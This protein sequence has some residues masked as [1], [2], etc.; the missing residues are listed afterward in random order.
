[1]IF[2]YTNSIQAGT[3]AYK[4]VELDDYLEGKC[5]QHREIQGNE[6]KNFIHLFDKLTILE[7]GIESGFNHVI[8]QKYAMRLLHVTN[9]GHQKKMQIYQVPVSLK[10]INNSDCFILDNE[11]II[12]QFNGD[13]ANK[14]EK[15]KAMQ[16]LNDMKQNRGKCQ[17]YI[18]DGLKDKSVNALQF[19][20]LIA[21]FN[22]DT[23]N[24]DIPSINDAR[25]D[26]KINPNMILTIQK[27]SNDKGYMECI[28]IQR[29]RK[30]DKTC[31][32]SKYCFIIDAGI[33]VYVWCG[34]KANK[35]EKRSAMSNAIKYLHNQGRDSTDK[36]IP[37]TVII[38]GRETKE[39]WN[40]FNGNIIGGRDYMF[41]KWKTLFHL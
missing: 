13:K 15:F 3:A 39:F 17:S 38:E 25:Q 30:L 27:I 16:V 7:G 18:I 11:D 8:K 34:N 41:G 32:N 20:G 1:M 19:W 12:F 29:G 36:N 24:K 23:N 26:S 5:V 40:V 14:N 37:I 33:Y 35:S 10:S 9:F 6:S 31:L 2:R 4:T 22:G 21:T 28:E